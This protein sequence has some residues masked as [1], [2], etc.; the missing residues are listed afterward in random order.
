V[1]LYLLGNCFEGLQQFPEAV[2]AWTEAAAEG[3]MLQEGGRNV[4]ELAQEKLAR[5]NR[6]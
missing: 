4:K 3:G 5:M 1:V 2:R 6:R